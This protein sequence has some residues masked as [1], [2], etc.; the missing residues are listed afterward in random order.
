MNSRSQKRKLHAPWA[1]KSKIGWALSGPL[2]AKQAATFATTATSIAD[3]KLANQLSKWWHIESYASNCDVTGHSKEEQRAIKTLEQT[4]RFNGERY[5]VGLLWLEDK[6]KLQNK[7]YSAMGQLKSLERRLQKDE[8]LKKRYQE[9]IDTDVNAGYFRK[10]DQAELNETKDK[11]QW[12]LPHHPVI[13]PHKPEEIRVCN[14][15]AKYQGVA[16]NDKLLS[17]PDLLQSL[18][19]IIFRFREHQIALS[20]DIEAMF[21]QAAV[22][23]DDSRCLQFRW[24]EDPEQRIEVY[25]YTRHV[26]G[27]KSSPTCAN[28]DLH[29]MAKDNAKEDE[30]LVKAVQRNF[31][32]DDFLKS[33]RPPQEA[34]EIY[35]KVKDILIKGGFNLTKWITSD[36]EVSIVRPT[37]DMF[38]LHHTNAISTQKHLGSNGTSMG[39]RV[40][41]RT[42]KTVQ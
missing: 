6:V 16:L 22:P 1:V 24:R 30:N 19:G 4:I 42:L 40:V 20:A 15:A 31:Y 25:E 9:T 36:E 35:Q 28:Y 14:A 38:T 18:I 3:D 12:Y 41:S 26:F 10:V 23:S 32:M 27:A 8:A 33:V 5:E 13:N 17:G 11:L 37:W 29:Q 34:I 39:Q 7:F 21:L 2:P